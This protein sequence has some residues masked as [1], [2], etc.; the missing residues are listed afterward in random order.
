MPRRSLRGFSH[1]IP[2]NEFLEVFGIL[3]L[4]QPSPEQHQ[5]HIKS[6]QHIAQQHCNMQ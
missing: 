5:R 6:D 2:Q 4:G 3:L 1:F